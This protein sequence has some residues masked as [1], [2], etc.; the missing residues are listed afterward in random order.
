MKIPYSK[1]PLTYSE[2]LSQ[3]KARGLIIDNESKTLHLLE[4]IGYYRLSGYWYPLLKDKPNHIFKETANFHS[5][6]QLYC[7][8]RE[9]RQLVISELEKIEIAIRAKMIYVLSLK[10]G[11][12]W[13]QY[14]N[15]F[16]NELK[17]SNT[18]QKI[19]EEY[20]KSDQD[21]LKSFKNKYTDS[22][23]PAWMILEVTSFGSLSLLYSNLN[24]SREKRE[25]ANYFGISDSVFASWIHSIVYLRNLCAH[26][27]RL[28]NRTLS[29]QPLIPRN[30]HRTWLIDLSVSNNKTFFMLSIVKYL[31][32]TVNPSSTFNNKFQLLLEKYPNVDTNA[33]GFSKDWKSEPLWN[34]FLT[35]EGENS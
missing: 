9:L 20:N 12:F 34:L 10:H 30:P 14:P 6:F 22:F 2:Q 16:K 25:I 4:N 23:P 7:F 19:K 31:L 1:I 17:H 26:H 21:F 15:L 13:F 28:W 24:D 27:S 29:I 35:T 33:M 32:Q 8:D 3:L 5:A 18:L 11:C